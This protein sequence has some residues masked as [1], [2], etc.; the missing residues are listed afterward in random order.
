M[1]S[2]WQSLIFTSTIWRN[3]LHNDDDN[4]DEKHKTR[5]KS[6]NFLLLLL[7][8]F[9]NIP[10][11]DS[12]DR[13][14]F[15]LQTLFSRP[16][17]MKDYCLL[18]NVVSPFP[19]HILLISVLNI[20]IHL[21]NNVHMNVIWWGR[22]FHCMISFVLFLCFGFGYHYWNSKEFSRFEYFLKLGIWSWNKFWIH[23]VDCLSQSLMLMEWKIK[24]F[25]SSMV[26]E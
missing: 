5:R 7:L 24:S 25:N 18:E 23:S 11:D 12:V 19:D 2:I 20:L 16:L 3:W 15:V 21:N 1:Q 6:A 14:L 17:W 9:I 13:L 26:W 10:G 22:A 8:P 4:S